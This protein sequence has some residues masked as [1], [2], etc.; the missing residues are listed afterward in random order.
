VLSPSAPEARV[1]E[2][3]PGGLATGVHHFEEASERLHLTE[4]ERQWLMGSAREVQVQFTIRTA[5]GNEVLTGYRVQHNGARGPFKGGI[6]YHPSVDLDEIRGLAALMTWKTA[7]VEV[8]FGG[9]KGGVRCDPTRLT[10]REL[11]QLT[12]QFTGRIQDVIGPTRDI[13]AP[14]VNTDSRVMTWIMDEYSKYQGGYAPGV[15][16]GK[17]VEVGGSPGR[18]SATAYGLVHIVEHALRLQGRNP[19]GVRVAIQGF[20]NVGSWA[21]AFLDEIGCRV[22][23]VSDATGALGSG[24][25]LDVSRL[26]QDV[27]EGARVRDSE[28]GERLTFEEFESWPCDVFIPAALGGLLDRAAAERIPARLVVEGANSPTSPDADEVLADRRVL[29]VPDIAANAGGVV[30]SYFEWVQNLQHLRWSEEELKQRL[31]LTMLRTFDAVAAHAAETPG[32][33]MRRAA[34]DL[35]ISRVRA[36]IDLRGHV[37]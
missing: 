36:A 37:R 19:K 8:P 24:R 17:P 13:P 23:A 26:R 30:A 5:E 4:V 7:L 1:V 3:R 11:E 6:R 15:V 35:A 29:V 25:G 27:G 9:A 31:R 22:V 20:G 10:R 16:T 14:D 21:A 12:R 18:E 32:M 2:G 33:T 34:Y 28:Q